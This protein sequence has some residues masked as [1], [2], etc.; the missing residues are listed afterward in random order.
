[1][2]RTDIA[3]IAAAVPLFLAALLITIVM[4]R[5]RPFDHRRVTLGVALLT[6]VALMAAVIGRAGPLGPVSMAMGAFA[7]L[8]FVGGSYF[9]LRTVARR[10]EPPR[11]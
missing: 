8:V 6:T 2:T 7:W 5:R 10:R 1:L 9:N 3:T 11:Q 4:L